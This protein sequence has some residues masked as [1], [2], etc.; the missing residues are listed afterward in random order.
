MG[1]TALR[2]LLKSLCSNSYWKYAVFWKLEHRGQMILS[3]EDGYCASKK[4]REPLENISD[5]IDYENVNEIYSTC[6]M[7]IGDDDGITAMG[8]P[9]GLAVASMPSRRYAMGEGIVG[10]VAYS[11]SHCWVLSE[12]T[13]TSE[14]NSKLVP[15]YPDE[16]LLQFAA[17][18]KTILLVP[19]LP[20]GV[21][22]LGSLEWVP[23]DLAMVAFVKDR[24][25][26]LHN[27][28]G[29]NVLL[30]S[31]GDMQ[32]Q[33]SSPLM[34]GVLENLGEA[35]DLTINP[36]KAED[37]K[38]FDHVRLNKNKLSTLN[39]APVSMVQDAVQVS[40]TDIPIMVSAAS[41]NVSGLPPNSILGTSTPPCQ[42]INASQLEMSEAKLFGFS[43][44]EESEAYPQFNSSKLGGF[45]EPSR[46]INRLRNGL[47]TFGDTRATNT[48]HESAIS[49]TS[50][51]IDS[52][53][54]KALRPAFQNHAIEHMPNTSFSIRDPCRSTSLTCKIDLFDGSN[55]SWFSKGDDADYLLEAVV[56]SVSSC[57]DD[58]S[59]NRFKSASS[60]ATLL[61][62][63][64]NSFQSQNQS[65]PRVLM[66]D[67]ST[68]WSHF[69]S[70][71]VSRDRS[72]ISGSV[73]SNNMRNKL[74]N[75]EQ[76]EKCKGSTQ[77]M[78]QT[79]LSNAI[80][81]RARIGENQRT[82][83]RDRQMIQDRL[84][85]LRQLVP[86]GAKCSIDSLLDRAAKH[87]LHLRSV[88]SQSEKLRQLAH[89]KVAD[90]EN[91]GSS[92]TKNGCQNGT[93]WAFEFGDGLQSCPIVVED[94][95][96]PGHLLIEM[97]CNERGLFLE[98]A[99]VIRSLEFT[100]LKGAVDYRSNNA[101]ARF[102]VEGPKGFHRMDMFWPL[103]HLWQC[104]GNPISSKF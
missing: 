87:M 83:P 56:A 86:N 42:S 62:Q 102:I 74:I 19:V 70:S 52:E 93:S 25:S 8:Y 68:P 67:D 81:R 9:F 6:E 57:L 41:Q 34:S 58:T 84:K 73:S 22:Q 28:A 17:G 92:E 55:P 47:K 27:V 39:V 77:P 98:I 48:D 69:R 50:C 89:Q 36:L 95:E 18:I 61:G 103:M 7:I 15:E 53:L 96:Y 20:H 38:A 12:N 37:F 71:F 5:G 1:T 46:G 82:R 76:Q 33:T 11:R 59:T 90:Q 45:E 32:P 88:T 97:L 26:T 94:L 72:G 79:K 23:E 3:W 75:K 2:Q 85:E 44:L 31:K 35:S 13:Y 4:T 80:K 101:W 43:C 21:L 63:G 66:N 65:D 24:F 40:E 54:H 14:F 64:A 10:E 104:K 91:R 30:T 60:S 49:F 99:Q 16:W 29:I 51:P 78:R 100:I